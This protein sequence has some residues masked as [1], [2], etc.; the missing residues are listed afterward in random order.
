MRY[1]V[2]KFLLL[3]FFITSLKAEIP[4][5]TIQVFRTSEEHVPLTYSYDVVEP[6]NIEKSSSINIVQYGPTGQFSSLFTR[7]TNSNHT[8]ITLNGIS[9]KDSSTPS[10]NDDLSQHSFLGVQSLEIIKGPL[11]SIYGPDAIGGVI[12][13]KTQ[14]NNKNW[15]DM[16][17]GSNNTKNQTIKLGT[18]INNHILDLQIENETSDGISV[19]PKGE[20][21]DSFRTRNYIFQTESYLT[22]GWALKSNFI[23]KT[24]HTNLDDS[25][26]DNTNYS[27]LWKFKNQQLSLNRYKDFEFTINNSDHNRDYDKE[28]VTDNYESNTKTLLVKNTFHTV[29]DITIGTEH[30]IT[31]AKFITN[32]DD[33]NSDV[34]KKRKVNGYYINA[35]KFISENLLITGG[36]RYDVLSSF[37]NQLT[38]R[39]GVY[40]NGFRTSLATGYKMPTLYEMY[41]KDSYGFLGN[42]ELI[43]EKTITYELGYNNNFIDIALFK[44]TIDNLLVYKNNTYENDT[45]TSTRKGIETKINRSLLNLDFKNSNTLLIAED[46]QGNELVRRP[47]LINNLEV[48]YNKIKNT[49]LKLNWNYYGTYIDID[50]VT[51]DNKTMPSLTTFDL[52]ADYTIGNLVLYGK[53]NN[54]TNEQYERPDGYNQLGRNFVIGFKHNF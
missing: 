53:L 36:G 26:S 18:E 21:D 27:G 34:N 43:P 9:I 25:G 52:V 15:I 42:S 13:M 16:S 20:E 12:N 7:G 3:F 49:S 40:Y 2:F 45:G 19:Y 4:Q 51:Y 54:I 5:I 48:S 37:D 44:S 24:N 14:A 6:N 23:D 38:G 22:N 50:S 28:G 32:I 30:N 35:T 8:L 17:Y 46:S 47:R 39:T 11:S 41:G 10:G 31:H 29:A 1:L 33:Y